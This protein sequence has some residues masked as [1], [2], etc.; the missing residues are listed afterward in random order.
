MFLTARGC[1]MS[2]PDPYRGH[3]WGPCDC[4]P[5]GRRSWAS[6]CR[7]QLSV[8]S[9]YASA[10]PA[11]QYSTQLH[12]WF[13]AETSQSTTLVNLCT[14]YGSGI[15]VNALVNPLLPLMIHRVANARYQPHELLLI[16][17]RG[18]TK[19]IDELW[20]TCHTLSMTRTRLNA[21]TSSYAWQ[22]VE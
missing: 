16:V 1:S 2:S 13:V 20:H 4:P 11:T 3:F 5:C 19:A 17:N 7:G 21:S 8:A 15:K 10:P 22:Y 14:A 18:S 6:A 12:S 9:H